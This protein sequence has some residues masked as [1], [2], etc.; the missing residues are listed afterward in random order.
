MSPTSISYPEGAVE[1]RGGELHAASL[2]AADLERIEGEEI[3]ASDAP[4]EEEITAVASNPT[5]PAGAAMRLP[6]GSLRQAGDWNQQDLNSSPAGEAADLQAGDLSPQERKRIA[7]TITHT[8]TDVQADR[9]DI[10]TE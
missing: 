8:A 6:D 9:A 7:G 2:T 5:H 10:G 1:L 4:A 3:V